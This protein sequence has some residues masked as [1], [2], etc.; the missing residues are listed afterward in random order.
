MCKINHE[1]QTKYNF[2]VLSQWILY[3]ENLVQSGLKMQIEMV[4]QVLNSKMFPG[5]CPRSP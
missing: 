5:A 3:Y 2:N 1:Y 4:S